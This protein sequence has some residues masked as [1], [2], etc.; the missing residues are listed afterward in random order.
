MLEI[1]GPAVGIAIRGARAVRE[2]GVQQSVNL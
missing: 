2:P 1:N